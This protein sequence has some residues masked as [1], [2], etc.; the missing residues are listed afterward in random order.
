MG[1]TVFLPSKKPCILPSKKPYVFLYYSYNTIVHM[2]FFVNYYEKMGNGI[3]FGQGTA[4]VGLIGLCAGKCPL[5]HP[6][7]FLLFR[8]YFIGRMYGEKMPAAPSVVFFCYFVFIFVDRICRHNA[9]DHGKGVNIGIPAYD[10]PRV[11]DA[12]AAY[13]HFVPQHG[14]EFF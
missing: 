8:F 4:G 13:L 9:T 11:Q 1:K 5:C 3:R 12:V 7:L 6:L 14:A 10:C 2:A